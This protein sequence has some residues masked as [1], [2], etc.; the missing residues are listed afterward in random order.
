MLLKIYESCFDTLSPPVWFYVCL[1]QGGEGGGGEAEGAAAV[2]GASSRHSVHCKQISAS[3]RCCHSQYW[4][5][6]FLFFSFLCHLS[7][8][9]CFT[10]HQTSQSQIKRGKF[11]YWFW[12]QTSQ[13]LTPPGKE[14]FDNRCRNHSERFTCK[15]LQGKF[16]SEN[17]T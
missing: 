12:L 13:F 9:E 6:L 1:F 8:F 17:C 5:L 4:F 14:S 11:W 15:K 7:P 16:S 3:Q 10:P 2:C